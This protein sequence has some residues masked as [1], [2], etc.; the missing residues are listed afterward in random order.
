MPLMTQLRELFPSKWSLFIFIAYMALFIN[1]GLL[2]TATKKE[3][4]SYSYNSVTVVLL[5]EVTKLFMSSLIYLQEHKW[6]VQD[7]LED[8]CTHR[9]ALLYYTVPAGLYCVYNILTFTNLAAFDPTTYF[10]LLQLRVVVTGVTFQVLF[11]KKLTSRQWLSL[12][13]LTVGCIIKQLNTGP[14]SASSSDWLRGIFSFNIILILVQVFCSCF[15]GVYN[16]YLLKHQAVEVHIMLQNMF[17]Y[18]DSIVAA[19]LALWLRGQLGTALTGEALRSILHP[20]V[21]AIVLN[22]ACIGIVTCFFLHS[23]NSILKTFASAL[24][25]MFT[26][27]LCWLIFGIPVYLN[28][29]VAIAVVSVAICVYSQQPVRNPPATAVHTAPNPEQAQSLVQQI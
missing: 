17:L 22:N 6:R 2:V 29:V 26:A 15:A 5:A 10:L 16:E 13:L 3:D 28:T 12:L 7:L 8:I 21:L 11:K 27:V 1:Q 4:N 14:A 23:L 20:A 25:L 9:R 19:T 18:V 24:E